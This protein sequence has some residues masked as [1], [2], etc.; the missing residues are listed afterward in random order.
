MR[1]YGIC[2]FDDGR[3]C[4]FKSRYTNR[5]TDVYIRYTRRNRFGNLYKYLLR[6]GIRRR[7]NTE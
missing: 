2:V 7:Y 4:H 1:R 5:R 6:N 3:H